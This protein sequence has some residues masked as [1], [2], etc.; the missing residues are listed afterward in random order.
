MALDSMQKRMSA[1]SP[2]SPWRGPMVDAT[3]SGFTQGNRQAAA[4][5]YSGIA[6]GAPVVT[7]NLGRL[8]MD[9]DT[10]HLIYR[11]TA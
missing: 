11:L 9:L 10:G 1:I 4:Y 2:G 5:L 6:A 8:F 3:E 7:P